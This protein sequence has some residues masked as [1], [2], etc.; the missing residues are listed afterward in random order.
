MVGRMDPSAQVFLAQ[1]ELMQA[2]AERAQRQITSG[3]KLVSPSDGP[4]EVS[5]ILQLRSE[6]QRNEQIKTN[7]VRVRSEVETADGVLQ[8]ALAGARP[9]HR[10]GQPGRREPDRR[11]PAGACWPRK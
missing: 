8:R 10:A 5:T 2:R 11:G 4:D 1:L 3:K 9:R 6:L 7:L